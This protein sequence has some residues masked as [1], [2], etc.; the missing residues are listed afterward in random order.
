M[1]LSNK[2]RQRLATELQYITKQMR[3]NS[4]DLFSQLYFFSAGFGL[5]GRLLN[6]KWDAELSLIHLILQA[7]YG[8]IQGR[9]Q[10]FVAGNERA[11]ALPDGLITGLIETTEKLEYVI[12][13]KKD[14]EIYLIL[15]R[16]SEFC[17]VMSGN[18]YYL[19]LKG[20]IK[21]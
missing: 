5:V 12:R 19:F 20:E 3:E 2:D 21:I 14:E 16:F 7:T 4:S 15:A 11:V 18:G 1:Q 9:L 10:N 17:Y 13:N 6:E 8:G